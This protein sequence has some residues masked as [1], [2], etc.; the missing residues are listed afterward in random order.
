[1]ANALKNAFRYDEAIPLYRSL[2]ANG[3]HQ[4]GLYYNLGQ[5]LKESGKPAEAADMYGNALH[6]AATDQERATVRLQRSSCWFLLGDTASGLADWDARWEVDESTGRKPD[7]FSQPAWQGEPL[8]GKALLVW[9]EQGVGDE[10]VYFSLLPE[11]LGTAGTVHVECDPRLVAPLGRALPQLKIH[12]RP[13]PDKK[14]K[15]K[16]AGKLA[17]DY[18]TAAGDLIRYVEG[19]PK[20]VSEAGRFLEPDPARATEFADWLGGLGEGLKIG[21]SW[22]SKRAVMGRLKSVPLELWRPVLDIAGT[23]WVTLQYGDVEE[24]IAAHAEAGG[25]T[26]H[27]HPDLDRFDDIDGLLALIDGLDLV[28]TTSNVTAH[29]AG[30]LGKPTWLVLNH[31]PI[32]YWGF[33]GETVWPYASIR[34][35]RQPEPNAWDAVLA[36]VAAALRTR[37]AK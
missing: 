31:V 34:A 10:L 4:Y 2:L 14:K 16:A 26:V 17:V 36:E 27:T 3:V 8:D 7:D 1:M 6:H 18:Q 29:L 33:K 23:Q 5:A 12:P 22:R 19:W 32:W 24:E 11:L 37:T 35:F 15:R 13:K 25:P 30:A 9:G 20:P 21:L 28:V